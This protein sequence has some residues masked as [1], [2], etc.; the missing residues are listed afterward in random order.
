MMSPKKSVDELRG[1]RGHLSGELEIGGLCERKPELSGNLLGDG[2]R[3][4]CVAAIAGNVA[5]VWSELKMRKGK[6]EMVK[7]RN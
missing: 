2:S 7:M 1:V 5:G 4:E 6:K 3:L